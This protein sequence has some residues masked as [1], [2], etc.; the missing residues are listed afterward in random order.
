MSKDEPS[1]APQ[2]EQ[3]HILI[4]EDNVVQRLTLAE[5]LRLQ[6]YIVHEAAT[7]DEAAILLSSS[8]LKINL[9]ITDVWMPGQMDG[10]DLVEYIRHCYPSMPVIVTSGIYKKN[11]GS[12]PVVFFQKPYQP[13]EMLAEVA[14]LLGLK[15]NGITPHA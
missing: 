15:K 8:A 6:H 3:A 4:V 13:E 9:V 2:D 12:E 14:K 11:R 10:I 5:S 7:A 1:P